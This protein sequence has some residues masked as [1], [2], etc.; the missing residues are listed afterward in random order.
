M[1]TYHHSL[2]WLFA[3]IYPANNLARWS[4]KLQQYGMTIVHKSGKKYHD[5]DFSRHSLG[6]RHR[7]IPS[8]NIESRALSGTLFVLDKVDSVT[9]QPKD[10]ALVSIITIS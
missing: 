4:L 6:P 9:E 7:E 3:I 5:A 1:V 8:T 10:E 2:C